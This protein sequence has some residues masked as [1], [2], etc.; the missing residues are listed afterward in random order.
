M[1]NMT[2]IIPTVDQIEALHR[3]LAPSDAAYDLIHTHCV[4]ICLLYTSPSPR[5]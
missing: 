3:K 5:D 2:G 1:G 4:I